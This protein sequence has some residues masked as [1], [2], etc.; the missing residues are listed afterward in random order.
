[1]EESCFT[2]VS[3]ISLSDF[4]LYL[5]LLFAPGVKSDLHS[6]LAFRFASFIH[7]QRPAYEQPNLF[8]FM[9]DPTRETP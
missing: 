8:T 9:C 1:M 3:H 5:Y 7:P 6:K 4:Q 2:L